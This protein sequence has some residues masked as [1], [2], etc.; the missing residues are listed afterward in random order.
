MPDPEVPTG[1]AAFPDGAGRGES[2]EV[3]E[4]Q[5]WGF[6]SP[7]VWEPEGGYPLPPLLAV[8]K[9]PKSLW[10]Q[11]GWPGRPEGCPPPLP[12]RSSGL[13]TA[14]ALR[15]RE[16]RNQVRGSGGIQEGLVLRQPDLNLRSCPSDPEA[17]RERAAQM[18]EGK[19]AWHHPGGGS[20]ERRRGGY[21]PGGGCA[22]RLSPGL[23]GGS[24]RRP[25]WGLRPVGVLP[26]PPALVLEG[27]CPEV[28]LTGGVGS[29]LHL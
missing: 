14:P 29:W 18:L 26:G 27:W 7:R 9:S 25:P 12:P 8:P 6:W 23:A 15:P 16:E 13:V 5:S 17:V 19:P 3:L 11:V 22:P 21:Y 1:P 2:C 24:R 20:Q 28:Y 4:A 10:P